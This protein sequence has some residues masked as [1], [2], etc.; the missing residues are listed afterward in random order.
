MVKEVFRPLC[1]E[2][3]SINLVNVV[4][5]GNRYPL[6]ES[7]LQRKIPDKGGVESPG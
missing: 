5:N 2:R 7:I 4:R 3:S 6:L 1:E